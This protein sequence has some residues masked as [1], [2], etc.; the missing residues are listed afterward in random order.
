MYEYQKPNGQWSTYE[1]KTHKVMGQDV[2]ITVDTNRNETIWAERYR[3]RETFDLI[4]PKEVKSKIEEWIND[5]DIPNIGWYS[6]NGGTGK[7]SIVSVLKNK[8]EINMM[9]INASMYGGIDTIRTKCM[10]YATTKADNGQ[11]KVIYL[12]ELA[13]MSKNAMES[14]KG[15]I[16]EFSSMVTFMFSSNDLSNMSEAL[17]TRFHV[18]ELSHIPKEQ[19]SSLAKETMMRLIAILENEG[20]KYEIEDIQRMMLRYKFSYRKLIVALQN[21][22]QDGVFTFKEAM[23]RDSV[24]RFM[25]LVNDRKFTEICKISNG[26]DV[27]SFSNYLAEN[28]LDHIDE[29]KH[30]PS[31]I[32]AFNTL[33]IAI[34]SRVP[35]PAISICEFARELIYKDKVT[36]QLEVK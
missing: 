14:L 21:N 20:V 22:T 5:G 9:Q 23:N 36:F 11:K 31:F 25:S 33:M 4:L 6:L 13:N 10:N 34:N 17:L 26:I 29:D 2:R 1:I 24:L 30:K 16:E 19:K 28:W 12:N 7:D 8:L 15:M 18:F 35:F 27:M 3:P 32:A